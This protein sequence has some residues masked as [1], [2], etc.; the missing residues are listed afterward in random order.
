MHPGASRAPRVHVP[1]PADGTAGVPAVPGRG[2]RVGPV[3]RSAHVGLPAVRHSEGRVDL[4][5]V[6]VR[7][8]EDVRALDPDRPARHRL[9]VV[10]EVARDVL[11]VDE[12]VRSVSRGVLDLE[13]EV[14]VADLE[15]GHPGDRARDG[16]A[17]VLDGEAPGTPHADPVGPL[18]GARAGLRT[19]LARAATRADVDP[20]PSGV[21][22]RARA[23]ELVAVRAAVEPVRAE[24]SDQVV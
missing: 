1:A 17:R 5:E 22:I 7:L 24:A 6:A 21:R 16:P 3:L 13:M 15:A 10:A 11:D 8:V 23:D 19:E 14:P 12:P 4:L 18:A 20:L 2:R 9:R